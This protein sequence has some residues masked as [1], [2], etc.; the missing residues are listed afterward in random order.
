MTSPA[1]RIVLRASLGLLVL[2]GLALGVWQGGELPAQAPPKKAAKAPGQKKRVEEEEENR[3]EVVKP[4]KV[5]RVEDEEPVPKKGKPPARPEAPAVPEV[6]DLRQAEQQTRHPALKELFHDLAVP[7]DVIVYKNRPRVGTTEDSKSANVDYA[8]PI[9]K[10]IGDDPSRFPREIPVHLLD[11]IEWQPLRTLKGEVRGVYTLSGASLSRIIPYEELAM[12]KVDQ[13]LGQ[14]PRLDQLAPDNPRNLSRPE[15]LRVAEQILSAVLRFHQSARDTDARRGPEWTIVEK[16]LSEKLLK[17]RQEFLR[18]LAEANEGDELFNQTRRLAEAY[19]TGP[20]R[21][22]MATPLAQYSRGVLDSLTL[23]EDRKRAA[24]EWL[25]YLDEQFPDNTAVKAAIEL[26][27]TRAQGLL[28]AAKKQ[29][30]PKRAATLIRQAEEVL[31]NLPGLQAYKTELSQAHPV[32]RVG[33]RRGMMPEYLSPARACTDTERRVMEMLFEGLLEQ[34]P[35]SAGV[36]RYRPALAEGPP[37]LEPLCR[38]FRLPRSAR[39]SDGKPLDCSDVVSTARNLLKENHPPA[40]IDLLDR[41]EYRSDPYRVTVWLRQGCLDPLS[42]MT[43]KVLPADR[44]DVTDEKFAQKPVGSGPFRLN[45]PSTEEG[46]PFLGFL[47]NPYYGERPGKLGLP[48]I[49]EV[50]LFVTLDP[51]KDLRGGRLDMA[52]DL[53]AAEAAALR[54][55]PGASG[56]RVL[57]EVGATPAPNRR[58]WFLAVN[59]RKPTLSNRDVRRA[60]ALSINREKLLDEH[61]RGGLKV[62]QALNGPFPARSWACKQTGK[63]SLDPYNIELARGLAKTQAVQK[64]LQGTTLTL[65]YPEGDEPLAKAMAAL[66]AQVRE[67]IGANLEPRAVGL[68]DLRRDVEETQSFDLAYYYYDFPDETFSL[69]PLL[70]RVGDEADNY[71]GYKSNDVDTLL[72]EASRHRYFPKVRE[73]VQSLNE[74]LDTDMPLIPLWQLDP[75]I[76]IGADVETP[77][78]DPLLV[79]TDI[80]QWKLNRK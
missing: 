50:R 63:D 18:S 70:G 73:A 32:L 38:K 10:Y 26:L 54:E 33:V 51:V 72:R 78:F 49:H 42:P 21:T 69:R 62:H 31:P 65:K 7:H 67:V 4:K 68:R 16:K 15:Q 34:G 52:L 44:M 41:A 36:L 58:I 45:G 64:A 3:S 17:T 59:H 47:A 55:K 43:F 80:A 25:Q 27:R 57:P 19:G 48:R 8:R 23:D 24:R 28:E 14:D 30:D 9:V 29:K 56:V 39:W 53:T 46:R 37:L 6:G 74:V 2:G 5:I 13:F 60:L 61:F 66:A 20:E 79:F 35:D 11:P 71:L 76:A 77:P 22:G 1:P 75:L 40:G 12:E